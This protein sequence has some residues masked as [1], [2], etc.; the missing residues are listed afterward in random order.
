M[1]EFLRFLI[2]E[3]PIFILICHILILTKFS[4]LKIQKLFPPFS[5]LSINLPQRSPCSH[6]QDTLKFKTHKFTKRHPYFPIS[7][8][9][10]TPQFQPHAPQH[11]PCYFTIFHCLSHPSFHPTLFQLPVQYICHISSPIHTC[12]T[13]YPAPYHPVPVL[14][15]LILVGILSH[16]PPDS[17]ATSRKTYQCYNT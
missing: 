1:D 17:W 6:K 15:A 9:H 14:V 10:S 3:P 4:L 16:G 12:C 8:Y 13:P 7:P 5:I 2:L 11:P